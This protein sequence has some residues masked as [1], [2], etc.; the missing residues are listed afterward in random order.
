MGR[1]KIDEKNKKVK[2]SISIDPS[3][4]KLLKEKSI[5]MSSL[6]NKLLIRYIENG[7]ENL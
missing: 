3:I 7:Y 6:V 1:H 4:P 5:N 2:V